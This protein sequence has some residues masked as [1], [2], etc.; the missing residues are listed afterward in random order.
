MKTYRGVEVELLNVFLPWFK[1][2]VI[3]RLQTLAILLPP[4]KGS[5][6]SLYRPCGPKTPS[7][8]HGYLHNNDLSV[9]KS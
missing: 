6:N 3:G 5:E 1:V 2:E 9:K 8:H 4:K 7:K